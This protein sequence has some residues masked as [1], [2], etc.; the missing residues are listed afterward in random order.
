MQNLPLQRS[1]NCSIW[2]C[3]IKL[4]DLVNTIFDYKLFRL[5]YYI[6]CGMIINTIKANIDFF[7]FK[8]LRVRVIKLF[9][10]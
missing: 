9:S 1:L 3:S 5:T 6:H 8:H 10:S 7:F 2:K 4:F